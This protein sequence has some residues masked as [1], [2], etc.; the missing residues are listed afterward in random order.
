MKLLIANSKGGVGKTTTATNLAAWIAHNEKQ[1][2]ALVDLDANKNSVKWGIYRQAQTFLEKTG[3]IKTYHL[4]GQP[5]IDKVIPKIESETPN[6]ILDCGGYDSS[7][8]REAL[9]C[10]DAILIPTRPNQADV[11]STGEILELIEEAN[12][13]RVNEMDLDPLHVYIYITQ[14]PTNARITALDDARNA[15]KEVEDFAKVLDSVNY[16]RIAYSRAYGM[17]LG[18]IE[19]NIGA[20]KAAEEVNALAEELFK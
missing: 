16:D 2:V 18:V 6:V 19:L 12:N 13:I 11:E 9:L 15:F 8:F 20:S 14:V 10:S 3:S 7:G 4:F 17:G 1:D 5:E